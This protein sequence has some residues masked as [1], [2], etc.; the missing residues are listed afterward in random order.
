MDR[1]IVETL[2]RQQIGACYPLIREA[3]P[4]LD[5]AAW[6][7]LA[8]RL[9]EPTKSR[10]RGILVVRRDG[11]LHACGLFYYRREL[12]LRLG[13]LLVA[14]HFVAL[15]LLDPAPVLAALIGAMEKL[16]VTMNCGAIRSLVHEGSREIAD[17]LL[18]AGHC[19]EATTLCKNLDSAI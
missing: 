5:Q 16:A 15:D 12:D 18:S 7:R 10:N 8:R 9:T 3:L 19:V 2:A 11:R 13:R 6:S 14:D 17:A 4:N 1:L